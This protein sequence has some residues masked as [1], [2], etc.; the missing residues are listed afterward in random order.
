MTG[1]SFSPTT[2]DD[3][4]LFSEWEIGLGWDVESTQLTSGA[5]KIDFDHFD[6]PGLLA[7]QFRETGVMHNAFAVPD[8]MAMVVICRAKYPIVWCGREVPPTQLTI[9]RSTYEQFAVVP[10]GWDCYEFMFSEDLLR[11]TEIFPPDFYARTARLED[12]FLPLME[13][14]TGRFLRRMDRLFNR[15]RHANQAPGDAI[16][17]S[18]FLDHVISGLREVTDAGLAARGCLPRPTRRAD[19]VPRARELIHAQLTAELSMDELAQSLGVSQ[20]VLA[21]AFKDTL[22][23]SPY[24]Y[25]LLERL[26][27]VRR[28]LKTS[29]GSITDACFAYGFFTPSRF[30]RQYKRLFGELPSETRKQ[31]TVPIS[32]G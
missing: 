32:V 5:I 30:T 13:R 22:G 17:K 6:L 2:F 8:G 24:R 14:E 4:D 31:R 28:K 7:A 18:E 15:A 16:G 1:L 10:C 20:R 3:V 9:C 21:Y 19:I 11:R 29:N 26:H 23:V 12:A 25:F 27:A